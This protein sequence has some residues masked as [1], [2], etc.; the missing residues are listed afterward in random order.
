MKH[1][2]GIILIAP[3]TTV[4]LAFIFSSWSWRLNKQK[5]E[6]KDKKYDDFAERYSR[7]FIVLAILIC[8]FGAGISLLLE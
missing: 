8:C 7:V 3:L 1:L 6:W 4:F 5:P 2:L